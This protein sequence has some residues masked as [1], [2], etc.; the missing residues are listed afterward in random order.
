MTDVDSLLYNNSR[1]RARRRVGDEQEEFMITPLQQGDGG[2]TYRG[3]RSPYDDR[4]S[5]RN[6]RGRDET[7]MGLTSPLPIFAGILVALLIALALYLG[8]SPSRRRRA[9]QEEMARQRR[10][11]RTARTATAVVDEEE[12]RNDGGGSSAQQ[13]EVSSDL[14]LLAEEGAEQQQT[15]TTTTQTEQVDVVKGGGDDIG[16]IVKEEAQQD[17]DQLEPDY[18]ALYL[19]TGN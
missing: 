10:R 16:D 1:A 15:A 4:R 5:I 13:E 3:G 18:L 19:N 7:G 17:G 11:R 2:L 12:K 6:R 14:L 9:M 8:L